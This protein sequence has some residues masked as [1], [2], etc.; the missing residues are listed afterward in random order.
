MPPPQT[1]IQALP[2]NGWFL[3]NSVRAFHD[4]VAALSL[5]MGFEGLAASLIDCRPVPEDRHCSR[6]SLRHDRIVPAQGHQE[7]LA[8]LRR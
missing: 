1:L 6:H 8:R 3:E 5:K 4:S 2:P 7:A